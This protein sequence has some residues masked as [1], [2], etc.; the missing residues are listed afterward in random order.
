M[1]IRLDFMKGTIRQDVA[2]LS[3]KMLQGGIEGLNQIADLLVGIAQVLAPVDTGTLRDSIRKE[4]GTP[5]VLGLESKATIRVLA[6]GSQYI[7]PRTGKPCTY[8]AIAEAKYPYM[9]PAW[10]QVRAEAIETIKARVMEKI[11]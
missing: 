2:Q 8:A 1:S 4:T 10:E 7:N 6:G 3:Q 9:R 5:Q 11:V